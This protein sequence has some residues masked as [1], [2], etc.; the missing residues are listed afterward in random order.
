MT[1]PAPSFPCPHCGGKV[2]VSGEPADQPGVV[3]G[4]AVSRA[5]ALVCRRYGVTRSALLNKSRRGSLVVAR[6]IIWW[7]VVRRFGL[8]LAETGRR[9]GTDHSTV[10]TAVRNMDRAR[11]S[12][13]ELAQAVDSIATDLASRIVPVP[14]LRLDS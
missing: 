6:H 11:E 12:N 9:F 2:F 8:S 4:D 5:M 1:S 10:R 7:I 3:H 13:Q 14:T